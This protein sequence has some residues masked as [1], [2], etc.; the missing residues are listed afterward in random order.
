MIYYINEIFLSRQGEGFNQG[1][2]MVFIRLAGCNL[3]CEW[4]DTEYHSYT[5]YTLTRILEE[6]KQYDCKSALITGGEPAAQNLTELLTALKENGYW[7]AIETNGTL[8]LKRYE[9]LIDY[10][11]VSP[12]KQIKQNTATE[13]RIV[14][15]QR[16]LIEILEIEEKINAANHFISPLEINGKMN[17][18]ETMILV[19]Q[20]NQHSKNHWYISLQLH[21]LAGIR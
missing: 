5:E 7:T 21:K 4:C 18:M 9:G 12:K 13:I 6:I 3:S 17:I 19:D 14:N 10:I 11:A 20:L 8:S 1:K 16:T 15:D 2:E